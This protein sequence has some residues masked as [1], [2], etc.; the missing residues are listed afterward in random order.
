M[1]G[2]RSW[3]CFL[4]VTTFPGLLICACHGVP[5]SAIRTN[6]HLVD[7]ASQLS[8]ELWA[9]I[10][11]LAGPDLCG[12]YANFEF[13]WPFL[14]TVSTMWALQKRHRGLQLVCKVFR[15]VFIAYPVFSEAIALAGARQ[16][17]LPSLLSWLGN[18]SSS[19]RTLAS[20]ASGAGGSAWHLEMVLASLVAPAPALHTL[21]ASGASPRAM[22]VLPVFT[23]LQQCDLT[24][25]HHGTD[26]L[27]DLSPLQALPSLETLK[28]QRGEFC[29]LHALPYLTLLRV[30]E[31]SVESQQ[32]TLFAR[33]LR[34]L[35]V[36]HSRIEGFH[37][38]GVCAC[39]VLDRLDILNSKIGALQGHHNVAFDVRVN[40]SFQVPESMTSLTSLSS[41]SVQSGVRQSHRWVYM[42]TSLTAIDFKSYGVAN[43]TI[44]AEL[45]QLQGLQAFRVSGRESGLDASTLILQVDWDLMLH[46][47]DVN[48]I[49]HTIICDVKILQ[50]AS[51]KSL[52]S[53]EFDACMPADQTTMHNMALLA[54]AAAFQPNKYISVNGHVEI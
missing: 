32:N 38:S 15:N 44:P 9:R 20:G 45:T 27:L 14:E 24:A 17:S 43:L 6:N 5:C 36:V 25:P 13:Q 29:N 47:K 23:S 3:P 18:H 11:R 46:L 31:S 41:L 12:L 26:A 42:L 51:A 21:I 54:H 40:H 8:P 16:T 2:D 7:R 35:C 33:S 52:V 34:E 30:A 53:V 39:M 19:V 10:L 28:L 4:A 1:I 37:V 49:W 50:L 22:A 48:I